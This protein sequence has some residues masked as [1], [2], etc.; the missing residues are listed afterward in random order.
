MPVQVSTTL[1]P[2]AEALRPLGCDSLA[3]D[4]PPVPAPVLGK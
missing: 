1:V 3:T 4:P 2:S